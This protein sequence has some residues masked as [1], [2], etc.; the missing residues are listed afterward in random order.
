MN[1]NDDVIREWFYRLPKGYAEA[2]YSE[3]ELFVLADV[4]AEHDATVGKPIPEAVELVTE[5]EEDQ[6][7]IDDSQPSDETKPPGISTEAW[8]EILIQLFENKAKL[9]QVNILAAATMK[10]Y[11]P[12]WAT[13]IGF[14]QSGMMVL[15]NWIEYADKFLENLGQSST[16]VT[17]GLLVEYAI[18]Q[19][20]KEKGLDVAELAG[21]GATRKGIDVIIAGDDIEVKSKAKYREVDMSLQTSFPKDNPNA[22]YIIASGTS[23]PDLNLRLINSQLLRRALLG[24]ELYD[25]QINAAALE[26]AV[27]DVLTSYNLKDL[28][29]K[30]ISG[31]DTSD[32]KKSYSL[33]NGVSINFKVFFAVNSIRDLEAAAKANNKG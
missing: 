26:K 6:V 17:A 31:D 18:G 30:S 11:T 27:D 15:K 3:S 2:P 4:I 7:D 13:K 8:R 1:I 32:I 33:G 9:T 24:E 12:S 23:N 25:T 22:Y 28:L 14:D 10:Y 20:A 19:L 5:E 16:G 29:L 21:A